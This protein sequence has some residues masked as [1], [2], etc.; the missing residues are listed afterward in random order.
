MLCA[1]DVLGEI[2]AATTPAGG[3]SLTTTPQVI[4]LP[5]GTSQVMLEG[6][7]YSTAVVVQAALSPYLLVLKTADS[8]ATVT[9]YS[10]AAQ[11]GDA[12]TD[13]VLSSLDTLANGDALWLGS[14]LPFRG[15]LV[16]VDAAN[17]NAATLAAH[18]WNG[19][20]LATLTPTD[21]TASGGATFAQDGPITWTVPSDWVKA[22]LREIAT[23]DG[24]VPFSREPIYWARLSVSAALDASTT[25]NSVL[26]LA[27]S[28][29][30]AEL[31]TGRVLEA[32]VL[33]GVG[34]VAGI[35]AR[36]DAGTAA[37]IVNVG[38]SGGSRLG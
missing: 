2:R 19:T 1:T 14:H 36:T 22:T 32:N 30:Y 34:G 23:A 5:V 13:V 33:R 25:L 20:A 27:R 35:E 15:A 4:A 16:D 9:D 7:N 28:T 6:R 3:A 38:V 29:A 31:T 8:L 12:A 18:Y 10:E 21:G 17:A 26:A 11:D 24:A 37:L